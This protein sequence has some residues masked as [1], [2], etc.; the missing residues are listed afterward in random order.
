MSYDNLQLNKEYAGVFITK[1]IPRVDSFEHELLK[2]SVSVWLYESPELIISIVIGDEHTEPVLQWLQTAHDVVAGSSMIAGIWAGGTHH[3][4]ESASYLFRIRID[5][6][7]LNELQAVAKESDLFCLVLS[8]AEELCILTDGT[9]GLKLLRIF[10]NIPKPITGFALRA[11]RKT[12][13][14]K[15]S[16]SRPYDPIGSQVSEVV[17]RMSVALEQQLKETTSL[18]RIATNQDPPV[19]LLSL[20]QELRH[21]IQQLTESLRSAR[22]DPER[23]PPLLEQ[24]DVLARWMRA[25]SQNSAKLQNQLKD[26]MP[27]EDPWIYYKTYIELSTPLVLRAARNYMSELKD[28]T[29]LLKQSFILSFGDEI[30]FQ[31]EIFPDMPNIY[32]HT[33]DR[34]IIF[35]LPRELKLR[36]GAFPVVAHQVAHQVVKLRIGS[37]REL[38]SKKPEDSLLQEIIK[39]FD[40]KPEQ[41]A[42]VQDHDPINNLE[43]F[44][45][46]AEELVCDLIATT[47]AGPAYVC[48][49]ARFATGTLSDFIGRGSSTL[50]FPSYSSR[51]LVCLRFLNSLGF[52]IPFSSEYLVSDIKPLEEDF[53]KGIVAL[54]PNPYT[55]E[56]NKELGRIQ[57]ELMAGRIVK[58]SPVQILNAIWDAVIRKS[59]YVNE[60]STLISLTI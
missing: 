28:R 24:V 1:E 35:S 23:K 20:E 25:I 29:G 5:Q 19:E 7:D 13:E 12:V 45:R 4:S 58:A 14:H 18:W 33:K 50:S 21:H 56:Q 3:P 39:V 57:A 11:T 36:L 16:S 15:K 34:V 54:V 47:V 2:G 32:R 38:I 52:N 37:V 48:A 31:E 17:S 51:V 43:D 53:V 26:Y 6:L 27:P 49:M 40:N 22:T 8:F 44:T 41:S 46:W 55:V 30:S 60:I 59:G 42:N 10:T 9:T